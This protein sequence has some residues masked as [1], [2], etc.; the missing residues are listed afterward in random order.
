MRQAY[1]L[2][3]SVAG[4]LLPSTGFTF[5]SKGA[6]TPVDFINSGDAVVKADSRWR[7]VS[8]YSGSALD[9]LSND[10][11]YLLAPDI[12]CARMCEVE[13]EE[14]DGWII[15]E[16]RPED[17]EDDTDGLVSELDEGNNNSLIYR[18]YD[19]SITYDLYYETPRIWLLGFDQFG[20][21]LK[22]DDMLMDVP[23]V[24]AGRTVTVSRHPYTSRFNLTVHPCYQMEAIKRESQRNNTTNAVHAIPFAL[25]IW[26]SVLP[27]IYLIDNDLTEEIESH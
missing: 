22:H 18:Y 9:C 11:Q 27:S 6:V 15:C 13:T 1:D 7:W 5:E 2:L 3:L 24:Y 4:E 19:V 17:S 25:K 16:D 14:R 8:D 21:P 23:S 26:A 12:P 20:M 10:K